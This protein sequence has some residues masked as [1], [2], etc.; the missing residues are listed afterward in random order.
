LLVGEANIAFVLNM[1]I[2]EELDVMANIPDAMVRPYDEAIRPY[3]VVPG[4][5]NRCNDFHTTET[6]I[7]GDHNNA[8]TTIKE[9]PK[10]CPFAK[11]N[12]VST[13]ITTPNDGHHPTF[14][15]TAAAYPN[16]GKPHVGRCP[17]PFIIFHDPKQALYDW[18]TWMVFGLIL[19][20]LYHQLVLTAPGGVE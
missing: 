16:S 7:Q 14:A 11:M 1:R 6:Q 5:S 17:W 10:E 12:T 20:W 9:I 4:N 8:S 15:T 3:L 13:I 18:Q 19:C 2:F